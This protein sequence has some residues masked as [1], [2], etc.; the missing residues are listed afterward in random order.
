MLQVFLSN[1]GITTGKSSC[2]SSSV[3][4]AEH[5]GSQ[6]RVL[7]CHG[8]APPTVPETTHRLP[9]KP[10]VAPATQTRSASQQ[11]VPRVRTLEDIPNISVAG[12]LFANVPQVRAVSGHLPQVL[13]L[14]THCPP[15][16][17]CPICP[18]WCHMCAET[19]PHPWTGL[20]AISQLGLCCLVGKTIIRLLTS[21][22]T[23]LVL[24]LP[25]GEKAGEMP[26][27]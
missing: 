6:A 17:K 27:L 14:T 25:S 1:T 12:S 2:F 15:S 22:E 13:S 24:K 4:E 3:C 7:V 23:A 16:H 9:C 11:A 21:K 26:H 18:H 10:N 19:R 8:A 5:P 20:V